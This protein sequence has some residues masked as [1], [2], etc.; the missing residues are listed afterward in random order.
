[1][2]R[3]SALQKY[4]FDYEKNIWSQKKYFIMK[5]I[6]DHEKKYIW[7]WKNIWS[8]KKYFDQENL[9]QSAVKVIPYPSL[10]VDYLLW[11][12]QTISII[13]PR[14]IFLLP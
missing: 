9:I 2:C 10:L 13:F 14:L 8:G 7:S 4:L 12:F 3:D 11:T 5:K 1:M 6:F